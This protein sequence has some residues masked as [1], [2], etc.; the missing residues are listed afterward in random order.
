MRLSLRC[1]AGPLTSALVVMSAPAFANVT[2]TDST[3]NLSDYTASPVF[4]SDGASLAYNQ[5]ASCGNPGSGLQLIVTYVPGPGGT[6]A[7][8]LA[9]T[10]FSYDP[11]T[12]GAILSINASVDKDLTDN[13]PFGGVFGNTFHPLIEQ[14]GNFYIAS[15][16]GP[17]ATA[18]GS[19]GYNTIAKS[20]LV[21]TDFLEYDFTTGSFVAAFPNFAGDPMLFGLGQIF[22]SDATTVT[23]TAEAD[24][25]NLRLTIVNAV[26][27]P[28]SIF[29]LG[30][31]I[32]GLVGL[33]RRTRA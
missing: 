21:A 30:A 33:R 27:E 5:C 20:G 25:D 1:L 8:G 4:T 32:A 18:P 31:G 14:D 7:V 9:N 28:A 2:F 15:I 29:L 13:Y 19:T 12:Q 11:L 22:T 6:A 16:P 17:G 23:Y 26:P 3:F 10:T 24:Y